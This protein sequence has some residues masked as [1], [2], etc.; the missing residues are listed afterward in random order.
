MHTIEIKEKILSAENGFI[1]GNGDLS[2]SIYQA[3]DKIIWRFGKGD[4]WDRRLDLSEDPKPAHINEVAHGIEVEGWKCGPYGGTVEAVNGTNNEKRMKEICQGCPPSYENR[5]YPCPKP[6]GELAMHISPDLIGININ[7]CLIIEESKIK[8]ICSWEIGID[9]EVDCFIHPIH[10]VL[11]IDWKI[12]NWNDE[13]ALGNNTLPVWFSLYRWAD[14]TVEEFADKLNVE[15]RTRL[16]PYMYSQ[17]ATPLQP[18]TIKEYQGIRYIEQEFYADLTFEAGFSYLLAPISKNITIETISSNT[19]KEARLHILPD[20]GV[21]EDQLYIA[22]TT[23]LDHEGPLKKLMYLNNLIKEN[24][25]VISKE[26]NKDNLKAS[27]EFWSKAQVEIS[28]PLLEGLWYETLHAMRC[29]Y[30]KNTV[31]PGLFMPSTV[32][33]YSHWHGDYHTNYNFQQPFWG[34]C[35]SNHTEL[36]DG[37]FEG[38][39]FFAEIGRKIAKEYYDCRGTFIQLTGYPIKAE[40]DPIGVVPMGRMAYMTGWA[41]T[42]HWQKYLYTR[43]IQWLLNEGYPIIK[44]CALFYTDFMKKGEDGLYH[45][46]PSNQGEDGFSGN[47]N[48]FIDREEIMGYLRYCLKAAIKASDILGIDHELRDIW[49]ERVENCAGNEGE[50]PLKLVGRDK[51]VGELN[52]PEFGSSYEEW[53]K[54]DNDNPWPK[55]SDEIYRW[56]FGHYPLFSMKRIRNGLFHNKK[57][58]D[59]FIKNIKRWR[60]PNGMIWALSTATYGKIGAWTESLG[61][62][63]PLQEMMLQSWDDA[64]HIFPVWPTNVNAK[65][66]KFRAQGA[67]LVSAE[68]KDGEVISFEIFSEKGRICKIYNPWNEEITIYIDKDKIV[69]TKQDEF[70][71]II[72]DTESGGY[73]CVKKR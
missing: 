29:V 12:K 56:Y 47:I 51:E 38:I 19:N 52:P 73:Y 46:F 68:Y 69:E 44:D 11:V 72:F 39:K 36:L 31:P 40:D 49:N 17:K 18:P 66:N 53:W 8:I 42:L 6:V 23:T 22:V 55:Y 58:F 62:I 57:D 35:T 30:K 4:V 50:E 3:E 13:T 9:I 71:R 41:M 15:Y 54:S 37:Y 1:L 27:E 14:P 24:Y 60:H 48:D 16:Y 32:Q 70:N 33:D 28:E 67:F 34:A 45:V 64:I 25:E 21:Y 59:L 65:F 7:Q 20:N 5:P 63:A 43:D 26:W 10:N 61:V 2:V